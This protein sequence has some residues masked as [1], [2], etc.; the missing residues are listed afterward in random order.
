MSEPLKNSF[1]PDVPEVI[2]DMIAPVYP[3]FER[4]RFISLAV[5]GLQDL[6]LT[7]RARARL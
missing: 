5:D 3:G 6:E 2:A 1:G 4:E 7:P